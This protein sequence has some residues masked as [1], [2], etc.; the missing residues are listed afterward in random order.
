MTPVPVAARAIERSPVEKPPHVAANPTM[1]GCWD[2]IVGSSLNF[3]PADAPLLDAYCYW[4]VIYLQ[5][6]NQTVTEDGRVVTLYGSKNE[7]GRVDPATV[8]ANPDIQTAKKATEML[9]RLASLLHLTPEARDR[10]SLTQALA[11]STQADVVNKTIANYRA[12][13]AATGA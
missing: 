7:S 9:M 1:S 6:C 2:L 12:F 5:A 3:E 4:Y 13:K 11:K 8:R 10:S